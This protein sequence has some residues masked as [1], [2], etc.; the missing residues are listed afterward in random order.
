VITRP[1]VLMRRFHYVAAGAIG[2]ALGVLVAGPAGLRFPVYRGRAVALGVVD[3]PLAGCFFGWRF[4]AQRS[5]WV[6]PTWP[7]REGP[8]RSRLSREPHLRVRT[9]T[10][11]TTNR[12]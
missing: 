10:S 5:A 11:P 4:S 8:Y 6:F 2:T 7:P 1:G 3:L 12:S 9:S